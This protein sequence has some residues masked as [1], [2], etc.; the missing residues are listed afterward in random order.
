M[1]DS[2][3]VI[4]GIL[5]QL[6]SC[7][8][9]RKNLRGS[10]IKVLHGKFCECCLLKPTCYQRAVACLMQC[11]FILFSCNSQQRQAQL[12]QVSPIFS[13]SYI[14]LFI[15]F[16]TQISVTS[17]A[18]EIS[19]SSLPYRYEICLYTSNRIVG[20]FF[21]QF[22]RHTAFVFVREKSQKYF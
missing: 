11:H 8:L 20:G 14:N 15:F 17:I 12:F 7:L 21:L 13:I 10:L 5:F 19:L 2:F 22:G 9:K 18:Y 6:L 16:S 3:E 4:L 1:V